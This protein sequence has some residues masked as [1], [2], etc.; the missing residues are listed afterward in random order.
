GLVYLTIP[1][2]EKTGLVKHC[3][4]TRLGGVSQGEYDSLNTSYLKEDPIENVRENLA[5]VC[6]AIDIDYRKLVFSDQTH[7]DNIRVVTKEDIGKGISVPNDI[8]N[9]DGLMTNI[10]GIPLITFYADCV[11]LF[12][13]DTKNKAAA[14][15]HS[16]WKGTVLKIGAKTVKRM[17]EVYGTRPEDCIAGIGPSIGPECFEVGPEVAEVFQDSFKDWPQIIEPY[18]GDKSRIN[19][20][21]TNRLILREAGIPEENITISGLCTVCNEAMFFSYRRDKGR[22]GSLSAIIELKEDGK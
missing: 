18:N 15:T 6:G 10:P 16:G 8:M 22:N 4:T 14:V 11:P 1:S 12:F 19:L 13:L 7:E 2:F 5:L 20:W 3:F 17:G 21:E 9:T